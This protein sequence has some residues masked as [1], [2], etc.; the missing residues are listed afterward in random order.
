M[1]SKAAA[2]A[3]SSAVTQAGAEDACT[4]ML[5][6]L[7][8]MKD[9]R[10]AS[11]PPPSR[12]QLQAATGQLKVEVA[13]VGLLYNQGTPPGDTEAAS[14]LDGFQQAAC[15]L[16]MAYAGLAAGGGGPTLRASL[17][18]TA[19]S[20]V[21][22][23]VALVR[24][25]VGGGARDAQLMMLSGFALEMLEAAGRAPLDNRAAIGRAV[26]QVGVPGVLLV[27]WR[28]GWRVVGGR[29]R[30]GRCNIPGSVRAWHSPCTP[31]RTS[32]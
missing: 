30:R 24:G 13:K 5:A 7:D 3:A 8:A 22:A 6:A 23:C 4:T 15:T 28:F 12:Q 16:C 26:T 9:S 21:Q 19:T 32:P 29:R 27:Q 11:C 1:S 17:H 14:L 18:S 20:V 2:S 25:A 10:D 31:P